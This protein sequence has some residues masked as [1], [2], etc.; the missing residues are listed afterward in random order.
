[1]IESSSGSALTVDV[2]I[3]FITFNLEG[4][5]AADCNSGVVLQTRNWL[6]I[7]HPAD[8]GGG[9]ARGLAGQYGQ[10]VDW[11]GLVSRANCDDGRRLVVHG[12]HLQVGLSG[13]GARHAEG[14]ADEESLIF[15]P[16]TWEQQMVNC[17]DQQSNIS[18]PW[19]ERL[20]SGETWKV[21]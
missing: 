7:L 15:H 2:K 17:G 14:G 8:S 12:R 19:I 10:G 13:D 9:G 16:D 5:R 18:L 3:F 11:Q 4:A 20:P 6:H 1:M 21:P